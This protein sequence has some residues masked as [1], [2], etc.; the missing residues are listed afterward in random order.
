MPLGEG[1][2]LAESAPEMEWS[3]IEQTDLGKI[4]WL[5]CKVPLEEFDARILAAP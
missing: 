3:E 4:S 2:Q 5:N 1:G